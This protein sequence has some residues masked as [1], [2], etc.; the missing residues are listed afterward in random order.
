M[1]EVRLSLDEMIFAAIAATRRMMN[2]AEHGYQ[3]RAGMDDKDGW[4]RHLLGAAGEVAAAKALNRYWNGDPAAF[5]AADIGQRLQVRTRRCHWHELIIYPNDN[6][7]H[8]YL[9]VTGTPPALVVRGWILGAEGMFP[10]WLTAPDN[11]RPAA[12][13]VPQKHL[14]DVT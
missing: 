3:H 5:K 9:L 12:Y 4:T 13:F 11:G 7:E 2:A 6:P 14:E 8:A 1:I 10:A